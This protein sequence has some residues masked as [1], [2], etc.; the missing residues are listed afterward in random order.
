MSKGA[1]MRPAIAGMCL[2]CC[3]SIF[4]QDEPCS[5]AGSFDRK[6]DLI[7][8]TKSNMTPFTLTANAI[9]S[10]LD[11]TIGQ[12][13][14]DAYDAVTAHFNT[15]SETMDLFALNL[16]IGGA[17]YI[18]GSA[19]NLTEL[20]YGCTR[21]AHIVAFVHE[22]IVNQ[23][24]WQKVAHAIRSGDPR[25]IPI[26]EFR[27]IAQDPRANKHLKNGILVHFGGTLKTAWRAGELADL[28]SGES[29]GLV[30]S[31]I[32]AA[33]VIATDL[34]RVPS[35][36]I[37]GSIWVDLV[38]DPRITSEQWQAYRD[39]AL[40]ED[41]LWEEL[42]DVENFDSN[43]WEQIDAGELP[44]LASYTDHLSVNVRDYFFVQRRELQ[45]LRDAILQGNWPETLTEEEL[46]RLSQHFYAIAL[47]E[48]QLSDSTVSMLN[49]IGVTGVEQWNPW[50]RTP[51]AE[52]GLDSGT[53]TLRWGA[54][55]ATIDFGSVGLKYVDERMA[56]MDELISLVDAEEVAVDS[57]TWSLFVQADR[58][59][60]GVARD[61][62]FQVERVQFDL[63]PQLG[64]GWG[65]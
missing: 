37:D 29:R 26:E 35:E 21:L 57:E 58:N 28:F 2:F 27:S 24:K 41:S 64:T 38:N 8:V 50:I 46:G 49:N 31:M 61:L 65:E 60:A 62:A 18:L 54:D 20:D 45:N 33:D 52:A 30:L 32:V 22:L 11:N 51:G 59:Y 55:D 7:L 15:H 47:A 44:P 36:E 56:H 19:T 5:L 17:G 42:S 1:I 48:N 12:E 14:Y 3:V 4:G 34:T 10:A 39:S 40:F 63:A 6:W 13:A 9:L 16:L 53:W 25:D 23:S 43:R